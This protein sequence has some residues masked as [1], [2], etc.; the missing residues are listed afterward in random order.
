MIDIAKLSDEEIV[1][2]V[3]EKDK[4]LYSHIIRRYQNKLMRYVISLVTNEAKAADVVQET[5][6]KAYVNLNNFNLKKKFSSWIYRIAHNE[7]MNTFRYKKQ[8][9]LF[10]N[11]D[12][13]SGVNLEDDLV[14]KE[15]QV[16]VK[17]CFAQMP[18]IYREPLSLY[19]LEE[20]SYEE[21]SDILRMPIGTVGTRIN[22]AKLI[23]KKICQKIKS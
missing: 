17:E 14:K 8:I 4:E 23:M 20:K 15:L 12:F 6:I 7:S 1:K 16:Y 10:D 11:I 5:F 22:R 19:F 3:R 9:S 21:I 13:D 18:I 2:L